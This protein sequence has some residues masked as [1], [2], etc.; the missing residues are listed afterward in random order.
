MSNAFKGILI[1]IAISHLILIVIPVLETLYS[2]ITKKNK[3]FWCAF[4]IF[5][6]FVGA[7]IFHFRYRSSIFQEDSHT[8]KRAVIDAEK[9]TYSQYGKN[10]KD[11]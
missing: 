8:T 5:L 7:A 4:L 1:L 10:Y 3:M 6:P 11:H 2:S 9:Q